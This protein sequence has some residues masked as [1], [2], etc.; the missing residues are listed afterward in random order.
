MVLSRPTSSTL[1][2]RLLL[3]LITAA[4]LA[5]RLGWLWFLAK[6]EDIAV[7]PDGYWRA[8]R[9][10]VRSGEWRWTFSAVRYH[11]LGHDYLLPPLYP[12]FLSL[13]QRYALPAEAALVGQALLSAVCC[14]LL[15]VIA[16]R[17]HS[18]RAGLIAATIWAI[19]VPSI[20]GTMV[21]MQEAVHLPLLVAGF[22]AIPPLTETIPAARFLIAG[23][24]LGCAALARSM[25]MYFMPVASAFLLWIRRPGAAVGSGIVALLGGFLIAVGP[26]SLSASLDNARLV[27]IENHGGITAGEYVGIDQGGG[28]PKASEAIQTYVEGA[29]E[30]PI[31]FAATWW[32]FARSLAY[33]SGGRL[34]ET[35][36]SAPTR[37]IALL[38]KAAVHL[39]ADF[40]FIVCLALS[41]FGVLV[42]RR[43]VDAGLLALW[44]LTAVVLTGL[45]AHGGARYRSPLEPFLVVLGSVVLAGAWRPVTRQ[46][47]AGAGVTSLLLLWLVLP[48][49][50]AA[51]T[52]SPEYGVLGRHVANGQR[53]LVVAQEAG[54]HVI[55]VNGRIQ[56]EL[57]ST[58]TGDR[59]LNVEIRVDG[60]HV[61]TADVVPG[62]QQQLDYLWSQP[63]TAFLELS[64]GPMSGGALRVTLKS[65][66]PG[67]H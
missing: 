3:I 8:G 20:V 53:Q 44:V 52:A 33:V 35:Y 10:L 19:W 39:S 62:A 43:P 26:Y 49:V 66:S 51:L 13:F 12:A 18:E 46:M 38:E 34:I 6:P 60:S 36:V 40:L 30:S 1:R 7:D 54:V 15:F 55:P 59:P 42:A 61:A 4:A 50:P 21:F 47:L 65:T 9:L 48:Q 67:S 24:L 17:V 28:S 22:A 37:R 23:G 16:R 32:R 25:P 57:A 5:L 64:S 11:Y 2:V 41:P 14:P 56:F 45:A 27:L 63:G 31:R 58:T 29:F